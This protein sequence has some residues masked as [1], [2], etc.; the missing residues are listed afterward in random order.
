MSRAISTHRASLR[1]ALVG[2]VA[3]LGRG[4]I[5]RYAL[6]SL[7]I[8]AALF[9]G[10]WWAVGWTFAHTSITDIG[11]LDTAA[12][13]LGTALVM[14]VSLA[15]FPAVF[16]VV[17]SLFHEPLSARIEADY[18]PL[19]RP[20]SPPPSALDGWAREG[21]FA[22]VSLALNA[23]ALP[24]SLVFP[25]LFFGLNGY[26]LGR[27][28]FELAAGRHHDRHALRALRR[29]HR[30]AIGLSGGLFALMAAVPGLNLLTPTLAVVWMVHL[31]R[32][33]LR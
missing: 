26:L 5:W 8:S 7:A 3:S 12:D 4:A 14:V 31:H 24:L 30:L 19:T 9:A 11:W 13:V 22:V 6:L 20:L 29:K 18:P 10:V 1:L 2:T 25:P 28:F 23:V 16:P 17:A 27:E 21:R 32:S 33:A 15:L